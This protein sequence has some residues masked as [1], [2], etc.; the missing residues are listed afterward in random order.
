M[1][2]GRTF[3][4]NLFNET[5]HEPKIIFVIFITCMWNKLL[6]NKFLAKMLSG[7]VIYF[8]NLLLFNIS[9]NLG[10]HLTLFILRLGS[11]GNNAM[12]L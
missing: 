5:I 2:A 7:K 4:K 6:Q 1:T 10:I 12:W 11:D 8:K 3:G 9:V